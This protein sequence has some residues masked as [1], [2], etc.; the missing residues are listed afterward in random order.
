MQMHILDVCKETMSNPETAKLFA[1]RVSAEYIRRIKPIW[2][3]GV[4]NWLPPWVDGAITKYWVHDL[5]QS[6]EK[7]ANNELHINEVIKMW[8]RLLGPEIGPVLVSQVVHQFYNDS[9]L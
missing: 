4:A 3:K 1:V 7:W 9:E 6:K 8:N 2:G 5:L